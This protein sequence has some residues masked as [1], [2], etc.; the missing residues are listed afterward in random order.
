MAVLSLFFL[1]SV[2]IVQGCDTARK[3]DFK[4]EFQAILL[5]NNHVYFGRV[6]RTDKNYL[7]LSELY[8]LQPTTSAS[9]STEVRLVRRGLEPHRP[10]LSYV[11]INHIV[12]I[13]SVAADSDIAKGIQD[14]KTK[15]PAPQK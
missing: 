14:L 4:T 7:V 2:I 10:D 15:P 1:F 3:T 6:E 12:M 11:N 9:G 13:E 5:D 8:Y